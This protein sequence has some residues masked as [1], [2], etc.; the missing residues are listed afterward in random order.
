MTAERNRL[1]ALMRIAD[2]R[3]RD[4]VAAARRFDLEGKPPSW[5]ELPDWR[6]IDTAG[7]RALL[8]MERDRPDHPLNWHRQ[9]VEEALGRPRARRMYFAIRR[10]IWNSKE[11]LR[12][13][14]KARLILEIVIELAREEAFPWFVNAQAREVMRL[15]RLNHASMAMRLRELQCF[16]ITRPA[17]RIRL[18]RSPGS[19]PEWPCAANGWG[20]DESQ[21]AEEIAQW[22]V[23]YRRGIPW[24]AAR[25]A[26]W[27]NYDLLCGTGRVLPCFEVSLNTLQRPYEARNRH[28]GPRPGVA[29]D[30]EFDAM[31][32][33]MAERGPLPKAGLRTAQWDGAEFGA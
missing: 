25:A 31:V 24:N 2:L 16:A 18:V 17:R 10:E 32:R 9:A 8:E 5:P 23:R 11:F 28:Y 33:M 14:E 15:A 21:P 4:A 1:A 7:F 12:L 6:G 19:L 29:T 26:W 22:V 20:V 3:L 30:E 27:L 13:T